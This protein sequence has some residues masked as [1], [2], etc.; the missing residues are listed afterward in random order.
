VESHFFYLVGIL[1]NVLNIDEL[2]IYGQTR[3]TRPGRTPE[4]SAVS[5]RLT[6][7][8]SRGSDNEGPGEQVAH[9]KLRMRKV[10]LKKLADDDDIIKYDKHHATNLLSRPSPNPLIKCDSTVT[11]AAH[12]QLPPP[13]PSPFT[14][15]HPAPPSERAQHEHVAS[16]TP[17]PAPSKLNQ[18]QRDGQANR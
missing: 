16:H 5:H 10:E 14:S 15:P 6:V 18:G 9:E 7:T 2:A 3:Q 13:P 1:L 12:A 17:R 4:T 11:A 8:T